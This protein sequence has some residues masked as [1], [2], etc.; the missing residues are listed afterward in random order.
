MK[1]IRQQ[2]IEILAHQEAS[3]REISQ[4]IGIREKEVYTHLPHVARSVQNNGLR[5]F[6]LPFECLR[7]H[8]TFMNRQRFS[9]PGRCPKCKQGQIEHP[10][11]TIQS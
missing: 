4:Q 11:Y 8:Y 2:I 6:C 5:L 1:T 10:R 7:C 9:K 3:A